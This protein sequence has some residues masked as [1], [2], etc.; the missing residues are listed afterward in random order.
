MKGIKFIVL[1][2][3]SWPAFSV[4]I[5]ITADYKPES[6]EI[7]AGRFINTT[8]CDVGVEVAYCDPQRPLA[9]STIVKLPVS[10]IK[11]IDSSKGKSSYLSYYRIAGPK[12]VVLTN[13][14]NGERHELTVIPT[15]IGAKV[16]K[17][18]Y[19]IVNDNKWPT[20]KISGDCHREF[21]TWSWW[22]GDLVLEQLFVYSIDDVAQNGLSECY[23]NSQLGNGTSYTVAWL[24]YGFRIKSPDPLRMSNGKY[25]GSLK[26]SV[27]RNKDIDVGEANYSGGIEHELKFTLTVRH[28]LKVDFP[29]ESVNGADSVTLLPPGG[30]INWLH[31]RKQSPDILQ[32]ELPFRIWFSAPFTVTLRCQYLWGS[33]CALKDAKG[34]QVP[35]K[36]YYVNRFQEMNLLTTRPYNF[37]LPVQGQPVMNAARTILFQVVGGTVTEMMKYPGSNFKGDVTLIFDASID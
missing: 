18:M 16:M 27:G 28:Q 31:N 21:P 17:M 20:N 2:L 33:E 24:N 5:D 13:S 25:T 29:K 7:N 11:M 23:F 32:Q 8:S 9:S 30:W 26:V 37:V 14:K 35:L 4:V 10:I 15:H 36:T 22:G 6:Y 12:K 34:R 3:L 19:P 1:L